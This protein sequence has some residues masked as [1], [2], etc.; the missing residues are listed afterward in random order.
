V[1]VQHANAMKKLIVTAVLMCGCGA[2]LADAPETPAVTPE[3]IKK[4]A[5]LYAQHCAPCHGV[6]MK[7]PEGAFDLSK[8]PPDEHERFMRS[9]TKGKNSMPPWGGLLQQEEIAA[10]W[11]YVVAGEKN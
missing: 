4:G 9:V 1:G 3:Q 5:A 2:A 10:L 6:R 11:A 7:D 8:F